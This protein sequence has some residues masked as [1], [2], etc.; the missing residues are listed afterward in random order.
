MRCFSSLL[1][2][3]TFSLLVLVN[4]LPCV[5]FSFSLMSF[6]SSLFVL[7]ALCKFT[8]LPHFFFP[9][10]QVRPLQCTPFFLKLPPQRH[11]RETAG[12]L[13]SQWRPQVSSSSLL[14][15]SSFLS[16]LCLLAVAPPSHSQ[17]SSVLPSLLFFLLYRRSHFWSD[18]F[19]RKFRDNFCGPGL[20][21]KCNC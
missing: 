21:A 7:R 19:S 20:L 5:L 15:L 18:K 11:L 8:Y 4:P 1:A 6:L 3:S 9:S 2:L 10:S 16:V 13:I 12:D 17:L 14:S